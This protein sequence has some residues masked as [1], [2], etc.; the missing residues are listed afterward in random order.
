MNATQMT[1]DFSFVQQSSDAG[2]EHQW[3]IVAKRIQHNT[4]YPGMTI[5][6]TFAFRD[7]LKTELDLRW[8]N[9]GKQQFQEMLNRTFGDRATQ[10]A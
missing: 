9:G 4:N 3:N 5:D 7:A 10:L 8:E 1:Y 2:L 6:E